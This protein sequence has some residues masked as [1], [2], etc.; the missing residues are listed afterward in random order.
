MDCTVHGVTESD[1]TERLSLNFT[2][3]FPSKS[4]IVFNLTFRS[5][6]YFEFIFVYDIKECSTFIC[7]LCKCNHNKNIK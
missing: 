7:L 3:M 1:M 4:F 6:I 2:S 5:L